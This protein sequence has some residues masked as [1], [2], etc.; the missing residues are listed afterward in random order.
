MSTEIIAG[1]TFIEE[2]Y[3]IQDIGGGVISKGQAVRHFEK[4]HPEYTVVAISSFKIDHQTETIKIR[5]QVK[6][7]KPV[8]LPDD[9]Q[10]PYRGGAKGAICK[11]EQ[12]LLNP[13]YDEVQHDLETYKNEYDELRTGHSELIK[14]YDALVTKYAELKKAV[15][16]DSQDFSLAAKLDE[17]KKIC[18]ELQDECNETSAK[19][20]SL[21]IAHGQLHSDYEETKKSFDAIVEAATKDAQKFSDLLVENEKLKVAHEKLLEFAKK[22]DF[23]LAKYE[24][25]DRKTVVD[26]DFTPEDAADLADAKEAKKTDTLNVKHDGNI[27]GDANPNQRLEVTGSDEALGPD[28]GDKEIK[29]IAGAM[30][31]EPRIELIE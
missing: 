9:N 5:V 7:K 30:A 18:L 23:K 15:E 12:K 6:P 27:M 10:K 24:K 3:P 1:K 19:Y 14:L 2:N 11:V 28:L 29:D 8:V 16:D 20:D 25:D 21:V 26:L 22:I 4:M 17:T 31:E 13:G